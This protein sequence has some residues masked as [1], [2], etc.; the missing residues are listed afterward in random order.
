MLKTTENAVVRMTKLVDQLRQKDPAT[1]SV[2][3]DLIAIVDQVVHDRASQAPRPVSRLARRFDHVRA[4]PE[5][6]ARY[7]VTSCRTRRTRPLNGRRT[8]RVETSSVWAPVTVTDT[9]H[10]MT[11]AVHRERTLRSVRDDE[12]CCWHR[13]RRV[14]VQRIH[15]GN[16]RRRVGSAASAG[17]N[18]IH[19]SIAADVDARNAGAAHDRTTTADHRRRPR[20]AEPDALVFR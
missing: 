17:R 1:P 18:R 11:R 13:R 6:L 15:S 12:R 4:D 16:R 9:G 7:W 14:P 5:R 10:G 8:F 19:D 20:S 2:D 3:V